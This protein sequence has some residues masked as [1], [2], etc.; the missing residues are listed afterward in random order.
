LV[1]NI[2]DI[3]VIEGIQNLPYLLKIKEKPEE[4]IG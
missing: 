2:E 3:W 4:S 1:K